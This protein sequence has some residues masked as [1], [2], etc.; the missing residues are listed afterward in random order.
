M[1]RLFYSVFLLLVMALTVAGCG[2]GDY[3]PKPTA[4][5]RLSYPPHSYHRFDTVGMPFVF[6]V[7]DGATLTLKKKHEDRQVD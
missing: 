2:G 7:A 4:Y 3:A 6:E 5:L 1:K